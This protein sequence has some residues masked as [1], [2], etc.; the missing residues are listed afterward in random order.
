[1]RYSSDQLFQNDWILDCK[2]CQQ[3]SQSDIWCSRFAP[4]IHIS[5]GPIVECPGVSISR[6]CISVMIEIR[7]LELNNASISK[8]LWWIADPLHMKFDTFYISLPKITKMRASRRYEFKRNFILCKILRNAF[9]IVLRTYSLYVIC[10]WF[11]W[12]FVR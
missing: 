12:L 9:I 6:S 2:F 10:F 7:G 3:D 1:M 4:G 11:E 5:G 8:Y